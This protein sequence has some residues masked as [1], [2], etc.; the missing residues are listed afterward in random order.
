MS[1][2]ECFRPG[3]QSPAT[4]LTQSPATVPTQSPAMVTSS[5]RPALGACR[6]VC[7]VIVTP[8]VFLL[9]VVVLV[10]VALVGLLLRP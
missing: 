8:L 2:H 7:G 5:V 6:T 9:A 4:V 1:R 10:V 3:S